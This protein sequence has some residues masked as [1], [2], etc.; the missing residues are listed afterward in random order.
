MAIR[1]QRHKRDCLCRLEY[2]TFAPVCS[3]EASDWESRRWTKAD[4]DWTVLGGVGGGRVDRM[5][6]HGAY[7]HGG[8]VASRPVCP[9]RLH[10]LG[11]LAAKA[12]T[13][14]AGS[15]R[16]HHS[17]ERTFEAML[18]LLIAMGPSVLVS[19]SYIIPT[20]RERR[21][22]KP[23]EKQSPSCAWGNRSNTEQCRWRFLPSPR[24]QQAGGGK[25]IQ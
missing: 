23:K 21:S 3:V 14:D 22:K 9:S 20:S 4:N 15:S 19:P 2:P 13:C 1:P 8:Q 7:W 11:S 12:T 16:P 17:T 24:L 5:G 10:L 6:G 18:N 25:G